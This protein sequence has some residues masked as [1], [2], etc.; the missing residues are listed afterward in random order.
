MTGFGEARGQSNGIAVAV[1]VRAINSRHLKLSF[2][3]S[4]GYAALEPE[5]EAVTRDVVRR[6]TATRAAAGFGVPAGGK[7][8]T[9]NDYKDVWFIGFTP[10]LVGGVWIGFDQPQRIM[11]NAQG[12]R[13]AAPAWARMMREIYERRPT[14]AEWTRPAGLM[15]EETTGTLLCS[16]ILTRSAD[17]PALTDQDI[18]GPAIASENV[19]QFS[20]LTPLMAPTLRKLADLAPRTL[21][22]MHGASYNGDGRQPLLQLADYYADRLAKAVAH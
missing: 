12:G 21:A 8:G 22:L 6:G 2:R 10:E 3:A 11:N 14:P 18:V 20:A 5:V 19:A 7:T 4:E 9:T 15:F 17:G 16:D 13:L 1:E